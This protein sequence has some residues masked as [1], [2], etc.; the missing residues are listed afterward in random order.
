M[1]ITLERAAITLH[2]ELRICM[3]LTRQ[4]SEV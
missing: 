3:Y 4:L 2:D 1:K